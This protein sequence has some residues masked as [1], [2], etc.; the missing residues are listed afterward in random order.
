M[1][2]R[3]AKQF[4]WNDRSDAHDILRVEESESFLG[5]LKEQGNPICDDLV[6]SP[7]KR[8]VP[9]RTGETPWPTPIHVRNESSLVFDRTLKE[10]R[11]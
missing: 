8:N 1:S 9:L 11:A 10:I 5:G 6:E 7:A 2:Y 3:A 4:G